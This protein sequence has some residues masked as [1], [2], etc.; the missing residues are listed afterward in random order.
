[1]SPVEIRP[2]TFFRVFERKELLQMFRDVRQYVT[3]KY[4]NG[5]ITEAI[6]SF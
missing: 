6:K 5:C 4:G 2:N 1:M 3:V